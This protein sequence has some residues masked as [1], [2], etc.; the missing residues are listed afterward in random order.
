MRNGTCL[1]CIAGFHGPRCNLK[2][3]QGCTN[4]ICI[5]DGSCTK[6]ISDFYGENCNISC[7]QGAF[8]RNNTYSCIDNVAGFQNHE[9][10]TDGISPGLTVVATFIGF[11]AGLIISLIGVYIWKRQ[12][13]K[14]G[15][16]NI[17]MATS[18]GDTINGGLTFSPEQ[19]VERLVQDERRNSSDQT[20]YDMCETTFVQHGTSEDAYNE[21]NEDSHN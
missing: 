6:C 21:P 3:S 5:R 14:H 13:F 8:L 17:D 20:V 19:D 18:T 10:E 12:L 11:V 9:T 4:R 15:N 1:E 7:K 2:C 16:E